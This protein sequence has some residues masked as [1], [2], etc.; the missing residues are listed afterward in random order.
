MNSMGWALKH[1]QEGPAV[2]TLRHKT[3]VIKGI[4]TAAGANVVQLDEF[5]EL[6]AVR[7]KEHGEDQWEL[8]VEQQHP[9]TRELVKS[10]WFVHGADILA[11][12]ATS[13]LL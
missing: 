10:L 8:S 6:R 9:E 11:V 4:Q 3:P 13:K 2:V 7:W 1:L 5:I 12:H